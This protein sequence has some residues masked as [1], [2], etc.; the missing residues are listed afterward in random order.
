LGLATP[1]EYLMIIFAG[2]MIGIAIIMLRKK[3]NFKITR[4]EIIH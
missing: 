1:S 3:D 2:L 4:L